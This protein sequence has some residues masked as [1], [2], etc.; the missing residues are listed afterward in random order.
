MTHKLMNLLTLSC[1]LT[2]SGCSTGN[3]NSIAL[4]DDAAPLNAESVSVCFDAKMEQWYKAFNEYQEQGIDMFEADEKA[5]ESAE[6]QYQKCIAEKTNQRD[7]GGM[8]N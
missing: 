4:A 1:L 6:L 2:I 3:S 8:N 5:K 7:N